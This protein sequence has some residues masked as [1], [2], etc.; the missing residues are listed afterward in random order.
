MHPKVNGGKCSLWTFQGFILCIILVELC[1]TQGTIQTQNKD[2]QLGGNV[3]L[4]CMPTKDLNTLL[5]TW[6]KKTD[7]GVENMAVFNE[8]AGGNVF[9]PYK[10]RIGFD[11]LGLNETAI[12]FW[13]VSHQDHGC[14]YCIFNTFPLG[15]IKGNPCISVYDNL[16]AFL[17]YQIA[18]GHLNATC[19]ATGLPRPNISWVAS[20]GEKNE[21]EIRNPN[22]TVSVISSILVN[23]SSLK[24][25]LICRIAHRGEER[26][27]KGPVAER[28]YLDPV[29]LSVVLLII[30]VI[31]IT[32]AICCWRRHRKKPS[33]K[34]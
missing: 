2:V 22:G 3:T 11:V 24:K 1:S 20:G 12:T 5:V 26:D 23:V 8:T 29:L 32:I 28:G 17:H 25:Q 6:Q 30:V 9:L 31:L 18:D 33:G 14:Y 7:Q 4:K 34:F 27:L 16:K 19:F 21:R 15:S 13:N 10:H